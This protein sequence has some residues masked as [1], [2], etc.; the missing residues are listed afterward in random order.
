MGDGGHAGTV[1]LYDGA[2]GLCAA[3]V[4]FVLRH[5]REPRNLRFAPLDGAFGRAVRARHPG[6]DAV[7]S[8]VWLEG[9]GKLGPYGA[10]DVPER[11]HVRSAAALKVAEHLG[12]AWR[13]ALVLRLVPAPL[14]DAVYAIV[15]RH[16]HRIVPADACPLPPP[17][18]ADRFIMDP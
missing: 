3:S 5:E 6:L 4:R 17:A 18:A 1:L 16:R 13:L 8:V 7:D 15:A 14:R 2:C 11:V 9:P 10:D 12:G